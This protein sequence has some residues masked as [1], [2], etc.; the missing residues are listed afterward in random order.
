MYRR[1]E[2]KV[3]ILSFVHLPVPHIQA[4][5]MLEP[6][7]AQVK[8]QFI[9]GFIIYCIVLTYFLYYTLTLHSLMLKFGFIA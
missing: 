8:Y 9:C 7:P 1:D 4:L 6:G 5:L 2:T 3:T